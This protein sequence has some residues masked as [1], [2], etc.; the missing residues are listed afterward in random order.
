M[1]ELRTWAR[2]LDMGQSKPEEMAGRL[3]VLAQVVRAGRIQVGD[4]VEIV[5]AGRPA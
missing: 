3:G 4:R 5:Q 2:A 1:Q